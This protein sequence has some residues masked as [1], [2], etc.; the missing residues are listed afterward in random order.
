MLRAPAVIELSM[1][2]A[3]GSA[4][5]VAHVA[6]ALH[7]GGRARRE[8]QFLLSRIFGHRPPPLTS[9]AGIRSVTGR[10]TA[11]ADRPA[12]R[13]LAAGARRLS[14]SLSARAICRA[15]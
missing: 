13:S 14:T 4:Q 5:G 10:L 11:F 9:E 2:S 1:T 8:L 3:Q 12:M 7:Q 6:E 15:R